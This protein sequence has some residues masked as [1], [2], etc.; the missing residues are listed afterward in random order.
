MPITPA[1][2]DGT[3]G[4]S[5]TLSGYTI[6]SYNETKN[7]VRETVPD[8]YNRVAKE[9]RY[10][11]RWDLRMTV[12]GSAAPSD[13]SISFNSNT[14]IV[15]SVEEAGQYNGLLRYNITAHRYENCN[16]ETAMSAGSSTPAG[17]ST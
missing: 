10:D 16:A 6:E 9:I 11:T 13:V 3:W 17:S 5:K 14:Y 1:S 7:P 4:V 15:D 2:V 8:Q 12:R